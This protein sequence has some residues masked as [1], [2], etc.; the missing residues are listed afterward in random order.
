MKTRRSLPMAAVVSLFALPLSAATVPYFEDFEGYALGNTAVTN[1]TEVSALDW[2]I[3]G[4]SYSGQAYN[5]ALSVFSPGIG[6][7]SGQGSSSGIS[8]PSLSGSS[9]QIATTFRINSLTVTGS[10][11][12]NTANIGLFARAADASPAS[13]SAD[14]Y[15]VS[16]VLDDDGA[17]HAT[18]RL[19][20][21]ELNLFFGDSL[22]ATSGAG[23]AVTVGDIYSLTLTGTDSGGSVALLATL[24]NTITLGSISVSAT[25][26][27][28][29]L[30]GANFGYI[31]ALRVANGGTVALNADFDNFSAVVPM[32]GAAWLMV[33]ALGLLGLTRRRG[34]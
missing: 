26:S 2:T 30:G 25:D 19:W 18:G 3:V 21:R 10:D 16:Y 34:Q 6:S 8:L 4:G 15:Q 12:T 29:L 14:R 24:T 5:D 11:V 1:F 27:S 17:G 20:L 9:F 32:P 28:N 31:N 13:T 33:S 22:N 23:L 7:A